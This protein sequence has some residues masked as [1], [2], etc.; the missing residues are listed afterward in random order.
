MSLPA[1][2]A[3]I[4]GI[5]CQWSG[6]ADLDGVD[7]LAAQ[8]FAEIDA[9]VAAAIGP[10]GL[11]LG[12]ML[13][14][15]PLGRLAAA[16]LAVP[17][18]G[19]LAV[20]VADGDDLHPLVLQERLDVVEALVAR[21]DHREGDPIAGRDPSA[22][23]QRR[24]PAR[25]WETPDRLPD[26]ETVVRKKSRRECSADIAVVLVHQN[27]SR[28]WESGNPSR[29]A[30]A[31]SRV[32][33]YHSRALATNDRPFLPNAANGLAILAFLVDNGLVKQRRISRRVAFQ[34]RLV[35]QGS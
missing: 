29:F 6:R 22:Q 33:S 31:R 7:V 19:A 14:D 15:Q 30:D 4:T 5:A 23:P 9:G 28:A 34:S 13:F 24:L 8:D 18:S 12:V 35:C 26:L 20:H 11:V 2:Q 17:V 25:S 21:A 1:L 16:D 32:A 27:D 10:G 3:S